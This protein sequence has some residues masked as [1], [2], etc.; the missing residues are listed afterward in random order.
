MNNKRKIKK[1]KKKTNNK[2]PKV[3]IFH[4]I[5]M[6]IKL[7]RQNQRTLYWFLA[8]EEQYPKS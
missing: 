8:T 7:L 5:S 2:R 6:L 4:V 1:K 3:N